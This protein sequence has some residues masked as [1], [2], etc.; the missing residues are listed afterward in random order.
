MPFGRSGASRRG[1]L[2][3]RLCTC[4][5]VQPSRLRGNLRGFNCQQHVDVR[6]NRCGHV[7][8]LPRDARKHTLALA[9]A[10]TV[11]INVMLQ[12]GRNACLQHTRAL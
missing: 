7:G 8:T 5:V 9:E 6:C 4:I 1:L 12:E 2:C 3:S 10:G 11:G